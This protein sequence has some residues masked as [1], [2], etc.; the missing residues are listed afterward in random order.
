MLYIQKKGE[1]VMVNWKSIRIV[2]PYNIGN[3][4]EKKID[5]ITK[6]LKE[7]NINITGKVNTPDGMVVLLVDNGKQ[8]IAFLSNQIILISN[9]KP[10]G[11]EY[12]YLGN[13]FQY[14]LD[15]LLIDD[16]LKFVINLEGDTSTANSHEE[17]KRTFENHFQGL[18]DDIYGVGYRF[19]IKD[20]DFVGEFKIEPML[21]NPQL[22]YYQ[23]ILNSVNDNKIKFTI[24]QVKKEIEKAYESKL[25]FV[26]E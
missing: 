15:I 22:F 26:K 13:T 24:N 19:L 21:G 7:R 2:A 1:F 10:D 16:N 9:I 23:L 18:P 8:N 25:D 5:A 3:M 17:S 20:E 4:G 14:I 12:E 6:S 11:I